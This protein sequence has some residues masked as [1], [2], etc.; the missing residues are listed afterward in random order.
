MRRIHSI[1]ELKCNCCS[2]TFLKEQY[3]RKHI[4]EVH[5]DEYLERRDKHSFMSPQNA[6]EKSQIS[7]KLESI[8]QENLLL[9]IQHHLER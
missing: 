7:A 9:Q 3:R 8:K 6:F 4:S 5:G 1:G 2:A